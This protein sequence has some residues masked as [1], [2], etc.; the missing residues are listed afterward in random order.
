[1]SRFLETIQLRD[2]EFKLVE[3]HQQRMNLALAEN[4]PCAKSNALREYL[5]RSNYPTI[6]LFKCRV[7]YDALIEK[8]EFVPYEQPIIR[9]LKAVETNLETWRY[10]LTDRTG[11][12]NAVT[13]KGVCDD[14][15]FVKNGL[16]T[17]TSYCNIALY[18]GKKWVT[19]RLPLLYGVQRERL[20][21]EG[22]IVEKNI[23]LNELGQYSEIC[24]FNAMNE[25]GAIKF[26]VSKIVV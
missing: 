3:Q 21:Q 18:D 22:K 1:M 26:S 14:V 11:L 10:K 16:L 24:L 19:P 8:L 23:P 15:L 6:G 9:S 25:F 4:Y 13:Q 20:L 7:V 12:Q 2:G 5:Q 17:D